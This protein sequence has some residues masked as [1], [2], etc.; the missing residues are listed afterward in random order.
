MKWGSEGGEEERQRIEEKEATAMGNE[1][2]TETRW[3]KTHPDSSIPASIYGNYFSFTKIFFP[4]SWVNMTRSS[5]NKKKTN[6]FP[7]KQ[8]FFF[9][10]LVLFQGH[11]WHGKEKHFAKREKESDKRI[12]ARKQNIGPSFPVI[13]SLYERALSWLLVIRPSFIY[14][15]V[16]LAWT[17]NYILCCVEGFF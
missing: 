11:W 2:K 1:I 10:F 4:F 12:W 5:E 13:V 15:A 6:F 7:E 16:P 3:H 9:F 17:W 14:I 8:G